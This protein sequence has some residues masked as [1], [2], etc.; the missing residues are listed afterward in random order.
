M[1]ENSLSLRNLRKN[2]IPYLRTW[3]DS[4]LT[5]LNGWQESPDSNFLM[6]DMSNSNQDHGS[7]NLWPAFFPSADG[8]VT[9][10]DG[11]LSALEIVPGVTIINRFPYVLSISLCRKKTHKHEAEQL[12]FMEILERGGGAVVQF[13]PPGMNLDRV[14]HT[15]RSV[16]D[17]QSAIRLSKCGLPIRKALTNVSPIFDEAYLA[18]EACLVKPGKDFSGRSI[19]AHAWVDAGNYRTYFLEIKAIQ[20]RQDIATG[21]N[22]IFWRN[23]PAW[24]PN[25]LWKKSISPV[26]DAMM[27]RLA[28]QKGFTP[29]YLF[30][31]SN[32]TAFEADGFDNGMAVK[33][34]PPL[35]EN[36]ADMG[37]DEARWPCFFPTP[38]GMITS[39]AE[40]GTPNLMPCGSITVLSRDPMI[41]ACC[42]ASS[43]INI[44][45]TIR[46]SL[47]MIRQNGEFGCGLPFVHQ[48]VTEAIKYT[49]N[50]S[51]KID[52]QKIEHA[53]L[54]LAN[55][56][57]S[58][59]LAALPVHFN[60]ELIDEI[61][62]G[63][64]TML[65]GKVK[66]IFNRKD[67]TRDHPLEWSPWADLN[68]TGVMQ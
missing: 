28:Y 56:P 37:N 22:Q 68:N 16:P 9:T 67:V 47:N 40:N 60:C 31:A 14:L 48:A 29:N 35:P 54:T 55:L 13:L 23:S 15:T 4:P 26:D 41:I 33:C 24:H 39:W 6:Y 25:H 12:H 61:F 59:C 3:P 34:L 44:R 36:Q 1:M 65:L 66:T 43:L 51:Y 46:Q 17:N 45:Y 7:E 21:K 27:N 2:L 53:G 19:Y 50:V 20:L 57:G 10:G 49:G 42:V 52:P 38:L 18:F 5:S 64:H 62:L 30:P 8:L 11:R 32:T 58:P 63:S